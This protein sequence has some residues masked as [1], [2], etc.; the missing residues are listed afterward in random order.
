MSE[1]AGP[2][3]GARA[4]DRGRALATHQ[5]AKIEN[6]DNHYFVVL[7]TARYDDERE[8][9]DFGEIHIFAG[10]GLRDHRAPRRARAS[11]RRRASGSR[12][13]PSCS[14][15]GPC[16]CLGG[17]RPGRRRLR[18]GRRGPDRRHRGRRGAGVRGRGRPDRAH[19]LPQARGDRVLPGRAPA[20]RAAGGD[21]ARRRPARHRRHA[22]LLPRRQRPRPARPRRDRRAARA[23]DQHPRGQPRRAGRAPERDQREPERDD[24]AAHARRHD[25][26]AADVHRRLLRP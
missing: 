22:E 2:L 18:A 3:P 23:V 19:L 17:P 14:T 8:Q 16:R 11:W 7:E 20:A 10:P 4:G 21:R 24:Q 15:P 12:R 9:V 6:Y 26:P 5:R 1:V 25:L 13:V